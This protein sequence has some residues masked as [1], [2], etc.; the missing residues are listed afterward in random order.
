ML[1]LKISLVTVKT[2]VFSITGPARAEVSI[3]TAITPEEYA[4]LD[5]ILRALGRDIS[6]LNLRKPV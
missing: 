5:K 6:G 4:L 3:H 2:A 1:E